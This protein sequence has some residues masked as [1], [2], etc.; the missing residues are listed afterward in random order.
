MLDL[1]SLF[2]KTS[3]ITF[4]PIQANASSNEDSGDWAHL[5]CTYKSRYSALDGA[6]NPID[7]DNATVKTLKV[8][9]SKESM[10]GVT[11]KMFK[12]FFD[13]NFVGKKEISLHVTGELPVY[14]NKI[15]VKNET[16][17]VVVPDFK[18]LDFIN[19]NNKQKS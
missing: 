16:Q 3:V 14:T 1:N 13:D 17:A 5:V 18:L 11:P 19:Q 4:I 2:T 12:S 10:T 6:G 9:F 15:L 8:K 7:T